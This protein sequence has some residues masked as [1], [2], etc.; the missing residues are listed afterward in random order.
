MDYSEAVKAYEQYLKCKNLDVVAAAFKTGRHELSH[1]FDKHG[2]RK[3]KRKK[4]NR[5]YSSEFVKKLYDEYQ[6]G[7]STIKLES[8]YSI[9]AST[10][11]RLFK[12]EGFIVRSNKVNSR[13]YKVDHD[14][15]KEIKNEH[16]A[17]WLGFMYADGYISKRGTESSVIGVALAMKD[18]KHLD[19]FST[20]LNSN[21][22]VKKYTSTGGF[23]KGKEY[24]RLLITSESIATNLDKHGCHYNKTHILKPPNLDKE[25]TKHFVR[26]YFDGDGSIFKTGDSFHVNIVGTYEMC[27]FIRDY[28]YDLNLIKS[29]TKIDKRKD[30][31]Q[32]FYTRF[33]GNQQVYRAMNHLYQ[34]STIYLDRKRNKY[35]ELCEL[36]SRTHE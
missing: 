34:E 19:K 6:M 5:K 3:I 24:C 23:S 33:G 32:V 17:Y 22:K 12:R 15:F 10:I 29:Q 8:E 26:G 11:N 35:K 16:D 36:I 31:H 7:H 20:Y 4:G 13:K 9:G 21:Y 25:L 2:L 30:D 28:F 1:V 18:I 14:K 27:L